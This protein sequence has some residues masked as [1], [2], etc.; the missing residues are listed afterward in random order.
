M[1]SFQLLIQSVCLLAWLHVLHD[2]A[3]LTQSGHYFLVRSI[4]KFELQN[5]KTT[6][7]LQYFQNFQVLRT[8]T[9]YPPLPEE[10]FRGK[11]YKFEPK[12]PFQ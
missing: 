3:T 4:Y 5:S 2:V 11:F 6:K 7:E 9:L 12:F 1:H 8:A 10:K